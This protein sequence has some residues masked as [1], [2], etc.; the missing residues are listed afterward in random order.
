MRRRRNEQTV[1][2]M[3]D[4]DGITKTT[5]RGIAQTL[6]TYMGEKYKR[7]EVNIEYVQQLLREI[8]TDK[9]NLYNEAAAA[10]FT[11]GE[12]EQAIHAGGRKKAPGRDG[13]SSE[14]Y[15]Q[16]WEITKEEMVEI[17][18]QIFWDGLITPPQKQCVIISLPKKRGTN[19]P[20]DLR[21]ITI[22]NTDYKILARIVKQRLRP[23]LA[24]HFKNTQFCGVPGN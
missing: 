13:L 6:V 8:E 17:F 2:A 21:P 10:R 5:P 16:I 18:N 19:E 7:I 20:G 22:L 4:Q 9:I 1:M 11:Q 14:F 24:R 15:K 3:R 23:V 12:T